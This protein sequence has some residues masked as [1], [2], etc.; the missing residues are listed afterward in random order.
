MRYAWLLVCLG[1][2]GCATER[3]IALPEMPDWSARWAVLNDV[4]DW[5]F[6]GRIGVVNG[7][8]GFNGRLRWR[9]TDNRF[10]ATLSGPLGAGAVML[11]GSDER[12]TITEGDG[13]QTVLENPE[14][15]LRYRYG[16]TI[17]VK[18]LRYWAL[19]VPDPGL[20][21]GINFGEDGLVSSLDQGGWQVEITQY[22]EG[23]DQLM[24][25]R[26][27]AENGSARVR[28]VIDNWVFRTGNAAP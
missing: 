21:A 23:G 19:G 25:R 5:S 7:E 20:P 3:G 27:T 6:S 2:A 10:D 12:I 24:P 11:S 18:S 13:T 1:T 14:D 28:L 22:R 9:Q 4:R 8:E 17:P 16:W 26:M 15:D